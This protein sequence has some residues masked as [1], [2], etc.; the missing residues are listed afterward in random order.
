MKPI[1]DHDEIQGLLQEL[2]EYAQD[3]GFL[4]IDD[5]LAVFPH[6]EEYLQTIEG[7]LHRE[8]IE[9]LDSSPAADDEEADL[10]IDGVALAYDVTDIDSD[11]TISLYLREVSTIPL[12]TAEEEVQLAQRLEQGWQA[13][14]RLTR[15]NGYSLQERQQLEALV[16]DG[17]AA[18]HHLIRA[19]S[20]LVISLAKK[21]M[22]QGVP[23]LDLIQEGNMGL[24]RAVEKFDYRRGYKFSTY[25]TWWI[26]QSIAR[27]VA[28]Q[29]RTIRVP[30]HM[31]DRIRRLYR[32]S[33]I[34]EQQLG[35]APT[36]EELAREVGL[37]PHKVEWML[38]VSQRPLS[39]EKPVGEERD[40]ELVDFI[41]DL[42]APAPAEMASQYLLREEIEKV[43]TSLTPREARVLK[44][45]FGL[46]GGRSHTLKE[47]GEKFGVTRERIRQIEAEALQR[48]RHPNRSGHLRDYLR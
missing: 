33:R 36:P 19:N 5:V 14:E 47:V 31:N 17:E 22:G 48:L 39:L 34:L 20:R 35:R 42:D 25:A 21:Y 43:L 13:R 27:A 45:R 40:S 15:D 38:R 2:L 12:L 46:A 41:E 23:F 29:G 6:P 32:A 4:T 11:D 28:D 18:R 26:R 7:L 44:L 37:S 9:L 24:M 30:V 3:Q 8:G 16:E 1:A 10:D